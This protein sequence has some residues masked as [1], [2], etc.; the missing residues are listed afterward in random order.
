MSDRPTAFHDLPADAFPFAIERAIVERFEAA[1]A[2]EE[3]WEEPW[4]DIL[5]PGAKVE[6]HEVDGGYVV[7]PRN[8][9]MGLS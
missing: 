3:S 1:P 4:D 5:A 2:A 8:R 7:I 9:G 6:V